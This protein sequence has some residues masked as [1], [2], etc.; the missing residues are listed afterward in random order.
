VAS[1][2]NNPPL[3]TGFGAYVSAAA[4]VGA[5]REFSIPAISDAK[6]LGCV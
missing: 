4:M 5:L 3:V 2:S 1:K 6:L